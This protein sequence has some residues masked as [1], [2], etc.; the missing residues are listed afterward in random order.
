MKFTPT[1]KP[2]KK[3]ILLEECEIG[4]LVSLGS[5][6]MCLV[7]GAG[8]LL[9]D[10]RNCADDKTILMMN[11]SSGESWFEIGEGYAQEAVVG[12]GEGR[13]VKRLGNLVEGIYEPY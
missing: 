7:I 2:K 1:T 10:D 5:G 9:A 6:V 11:S 8:C 3:K 4:E 13:I 12:Y